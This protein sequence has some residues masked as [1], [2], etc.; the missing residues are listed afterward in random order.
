M[1]SSDFEQCSQCSGWV[2]QT[3]E[4]SQV[5]SGSRATKQRH[6]LLT[7]SHLT[8]FHIPYLTSPTICNVKIEADKKESLKKKIWL[9]GRFK[10][11]SFHRSSI[12]VGYDD[13]MEN[14]SVTL[15]I[16]SQGLETPL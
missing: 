12:C 10:L 14:V 15:R 11:R 9:R 2:G 1:Q 6:L 8:C 3:M 5:P 13:M 7:R 4:V 16:I